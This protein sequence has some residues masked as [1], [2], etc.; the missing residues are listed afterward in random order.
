MT[1]AALDQGV[2]HVPLH[3]S[4]GDALPGWVDAAAKAQRVHS[5]HQISLQPELIDRH[6][7][8]G[9]AAATSETTARVTAILA[10]LPAR[11]R[12]AIRLKYLR[13]MTL[14]EVGERIGGVSKERARQLIDRGLETCRKIA[15]VHHAANV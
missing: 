8:P 13:G 14:T 6:P 12:K 2:I 3:A 11:T 15:G 10:R 1:R 4:R 7:G 9:E 5:I